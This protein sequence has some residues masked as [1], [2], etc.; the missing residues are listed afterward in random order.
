MSEQ[1]RQ[2]L[3]Q[4]SSQ[5]GLAHEGQ[6]DHDERQRQADNYKRLG[7][8]SSIDRCWG[9]KTRL[10]EGR[11]AVN[12]LGAGNADWAVRGN[13]P[14]TLIYDPF[15]AAIKHSTVSQRR[16]KVDGVA[17]PLLKGPPPERVRVRNTFPTQYAK[18]MSCQM[19]SN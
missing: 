17:P 6:H 10:A 16:A 8:F 2:Q 1:T 12:L 5:S 4:C 7:H 15:L 14:P 18:P 9:E 19:R 11:Q 3:L 13:P